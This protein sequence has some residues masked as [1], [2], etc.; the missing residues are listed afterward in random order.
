MRNSTAIIGMLFLSASAAGFGQSNSQQSSTN[1][2][3][4]GSQPAAQAP[5]APPSAASV[6]K[7]KAIVLA[8]AKASGGDALKSIHNLEIDTKGQAF[9]QG[10]AVDIHLMLTIEFPNHLH[11]QATLPQGNVQQTFDGTNGWLVTDQGILDLPEEYVPEFKR[12]IALAGAWGLYRDALNGKV[13]S[14]F[15]DEEQVDGHKVEIVEWASDSGPVRLYFDAASHLLTGA[16]FEAVT[17]QGPVQAD[18]R[19][20]YFKAVGQCQYPY[21]S[22]VFHNGQK[23]TETEVQSIKT[24]VS[25]DP[26]SFS[27]P[28]T[29]PAK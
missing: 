6:E 21:R 13:D 26:S 12:G 1:A 4:Q 28:Q 18:Q 5:A 15:L 11:N 20:S 8:A 7:G 22:V 9:T 10:Q 29:P 25:I 14:H 17:P 27:K 3:V 16:H 19:W 23:F 24:N 2:P